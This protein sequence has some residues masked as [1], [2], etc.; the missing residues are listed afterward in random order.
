MN[1]FGPFAMLPSVRTL[2]APQILSEYFDWP[3]SFSLGFSRFTV[4]D[5]T[6]ATLDVQ[7]LTHLLRSISALEK[8]KYGH[9]FWVPEERYP[10]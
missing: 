9:H 2:S 6:G 7:I 5:I 3:E 8:I 1:E 4:I 10:V